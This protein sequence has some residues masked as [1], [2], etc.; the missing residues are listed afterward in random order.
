MYGV[1]SLS[2]G[3]VSANIVSLQQLIRSAYN[4]QP[5]Q[6][7]GGSSWTET[8]LYNIEASGDSAEW[9]EML[10]SLL[11]ERF[12]LVVH[13]EERQLPVYALVLAKK[14]GK[15]GP[16]MVEAK[17][18]ACVARDPSRA[19]QLPGPGRAGI[20]GNVLGSMSELY[21]TAAT[22]GDLAPMLSTLV[23]RKVLDRSGVT[24]KYDIK[25]TYAL[26]E[27]QRVL[28]LP[29]GTP[30]SSIPLDTS[31]PSLFTALEEQLGLKLESQRAPVE[32]FVIDRA[33][34]PSEN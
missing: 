28:M 4:I 26:D 33:A 27:S 10:K 32:V 2:R 7:S 25:L 6:L 20:C 15:L 11:A 8:D 34:K 21:G 1:R 3:R 5:F 23:G 29:P 17:E 24:A 30:P 22:P 31:G 9:R 13:R 12:Q 14:D 16:A 18:G 19:I